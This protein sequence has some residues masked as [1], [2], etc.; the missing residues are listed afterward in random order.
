MT[1]VL[2]FLFLLIIVTARPTKFNENYLDKRYT[3]IIK[4]IFLI[5]V[6]ISHF[7]AYNVTLQNNWVDS[8]GVKFIKQLGQLMVTLFL[9]YSGYGVMESVKKK[10]E[11]YIKSFPKKRILTT[12]IN[13]DIAVIIYMFVSKYFQTHQ[14][15]IKYLLSSL[16]GWDTFGNS[17]WYIFAILC[18]YLISYLS[19]KSFKNRKQ[20]AISILIGTTLFT[21]IMQ[22]YKDGYFYNTAYCFAFGAIFSLYKEEIEKWLNGKELLLAIYILILFLI[23]YKLKKYLGWYYI[24]TVAFTTLIVLI[25]RKISIKNFI[26]EWVGKNLFPLYIFQRIPM[27]LLIDKGYFNNNTYILFAMCFVITIVITLVYNLIMF[28]K[29]KITKKFDQRYISNT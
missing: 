18:L 11:D 22:F 24:Y 20:R 13:F 7:I 8:Y 16:I 4:G 15:S 25:T 14:F 9:F 1:I 29:N 23:S 19:V 21:V 27:M 28:I 12:L 26:L 3:D 6:F 10:G 17:N 2:I 5:F